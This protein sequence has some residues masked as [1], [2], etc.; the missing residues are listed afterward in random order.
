MTEVRLRA[1]SLVMD[2]K[3]N[4]IFMT[5]L[6]HK[7]PAYLAGK[8]PIKAKSMAVILANNFRDLRI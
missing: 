7:I 8:L 5:F 4:D 6:L 1:T 3:A 2:F